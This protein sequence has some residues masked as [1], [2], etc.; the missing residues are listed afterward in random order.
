MATDLPIACSLEARELE[1]RL[2]EMTA[3]GAAALLASE[4]HGRRALLRFRADEDAR[5]RLDAII[6]AESRCCS[7]LTMELA[8]AEHEL[9]LTVDGPVGAEPVIDELARAFR[10]A[11]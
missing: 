3:I 4:T 9:V 8:L 7:F 2:G 11:A 6:D 5:G 1:Q 10:G